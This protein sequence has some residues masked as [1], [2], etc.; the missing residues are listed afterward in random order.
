MQNLSF[1]RMAM[2]PI[3]EPIKL[4]AGSHYLRGL[5]G[6]YSWILLTK[7]HSIHYKFSGANWI[8]YHE[9]IMNAEAIKI[10]LR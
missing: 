1:V 4:V 6:R 3:L 8:S 5:F 9:G 7:H 2:T 10:F